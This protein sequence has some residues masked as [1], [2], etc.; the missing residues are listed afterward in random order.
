MQK[1]KE[2]TCFHELVACA[3]GLLEASSIDFYVDKDVLLGIKRNGK[4][5]PWSGHLGLFICILSSSF[6][7]FMIDISVFEESFPRINELAGSSFNAKKAGIPSCS[8]VLYFNKHPD[9]RRFRMVHS[10]P[11]SLHPVGQQT[12]ELSKA[13]RLASKPTEECYIND[14]KTRC[15]SGASELLVSLYGP[16]WKKPKY[17]KW[18]GKHW[19]TQVFFSHCLRP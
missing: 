6:F 17:L 19:M 7:N 15:P 14:I 3:S 8:N 16:D 12:L 9:N 13:G 18:N 11:H 1:E 10:C 4:F 2:P 5:I